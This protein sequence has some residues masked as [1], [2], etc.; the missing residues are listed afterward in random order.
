MDRV[1]PVDDSLVPAITGLEKLVQLLAILSFPP[2]FISQYPYK[3]FEQILSEIICKKLR[4]GKP[5]P[6]IQSQK[7]YFSTN[8]IIHYFTFDH[9][10]VDRA[11]L[12]SLSFHWSVTGPDPGGDGNFSATR[13]VFSPPPVIAA[14]VE[15]HPL[16][17]FHHRSWLR[18]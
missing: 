12:S 3:R 8:M 14:Q 13:L 4:T 15:N 18:S 9:H 11:S 7:S 2:Y 6:K 17:I 16:F 5:I 1:E 10:F